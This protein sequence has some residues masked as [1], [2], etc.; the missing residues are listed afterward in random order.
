MLAET[1]VARESPDPSYGTYAY[2]AREWDPEINLYFYRARYYDPKVGRFVSEDP[3]GL[4]GGV[5]FYVY[6]DSSPVNATDPD[7][8]QVRY[9]KPPPDTVPLPPAVEA[10]VLCV[11][12]CL[13]IP[14]IVT[15]GAEKKG[16]SR[17]SKHYSGQAVDFGFNSNP[18]IRGRSKDFFCCALQCGFGWGQT[19]HG[20]GP[21][22]HVQTVPGL[23]VPPISSQGCTCKV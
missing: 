2:T 19:E 12:R 23:S 9:N 3:T 14:L 20:K 4:G 13:G 5:N 6:V 16:H 10:M 7:G 22:Y 8:L 18:G 17:G 15:G 21:H 11:Q 1:A